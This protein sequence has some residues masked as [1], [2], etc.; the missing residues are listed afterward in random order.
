MVEQLGV[1]IYEALD[2]SVDP[3]DERQLSPPLANLINQMT[4]N[5][6]THS[7]ANNSDQL[8]AETSRHHGGHEADEGIEEDGGGP[9]MDTIDSGSDVHFTLDEVLECCRVHL[10][11][12][13]QSDVHYRAVCRALVTEAL[14]LSTF[15]D[16][17]STGNKKELIKVSEEL[18]KLNIRDWARLWVQ[19][20]EELRR[21]VKLKKV[22]VHPHAH[23]IE[24]ALT[25]YE[26]LMDDIR[27]RRYKLNKV[28]VNGD[29][30]PRVKKD[31]HAIILDFIRSRP[32]L[33]PVSQRTIR[34]LEPQPATN[35][36][37][38]MRAIRS[39][40]FKLKPVKTK[41]GLS[42]ETETNRT[43]IDQSTRRLIKVDTKLLNLNNFDEDDDLLPSPIT[44]DI[45]SDRRNEASNTH[46]HNLS[47]T[48][49]PNWQKTVTFDL[50]NHGQ[51][52]KLERRHSITLC[53]VTPSTSTVPCVS[54][55][56]S[57]MTSLPPQ[58][59]SAAE[60]GSDNNGSNGGLLRPHKRLYRSMLW[61]NSVE[62]LSLTLEEVVH[63]RNVLTKAELENLLV[64]TNQYE[65]VA[66]GK[67]CFI[68]KKTKF[69]FFGPWKQVCRLC[70]R[71]IC[72]K[73]CSKMRIPTE[74]FANIPVYTLSPSPS[75]SGDED[76]PTHHT[77]SKM[78][79]WNNMA[80]LTHAQ[81]ANTNGS[82]PSTPVSTPRYS[83]GPPC[84]IADSPLTPHDMQSHNNN[85]R[86]SLN[87]SKTLTSKQNGHQ[88]LQQE[89][90][91]GSLMTVC[92][93]CKSM[94]CHVIVASRNSL[95]LRHKQHRLS[96]SAATTTSVQCHVRSSA[97]KA[98]GLTTD[99]SHMRL[100]LKPIYNNEEEDEI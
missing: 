72:D 96:C 74:H 79:T 73:C 60:V 39:N 31:A 70:R 51:M 80:A 4:A 57:A 14:E 15:L 99:K 90:L 75:S 38:L 88:Q 9:E 12:S 77:T 16:R 53:D 71:T 20:I 49:S 46:H 11:S 89:K 34:Q 10:S 26:I 50:A 69:S 21:G 98:Q 87:R 18:E 56:Q 81:L 30:P 23:P 24:Y 62:C 63:I 64:G 25:P 82:A 41:V 95:A 68:C 7:S 28:M 13:G 91:K 100:N 66:K 43:E 97:E 33:N 54:D 19:V 83:H 37:R 84:P 6:D 44:P 32:P 52:V 67:L 27:S 3:E 5:I 48:S 86:R 55:E 29:L 92:K 22:K 35:H 47:P 8:G 78:A 45:S 36:E 61:K 65:D 76:S 2:Y 42:T 94:V 58:F 59:P 17:I 93:E 1:V 85:I 40:T